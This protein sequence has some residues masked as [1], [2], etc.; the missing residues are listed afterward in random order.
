[1]KKYVIWDFNGTVLDDLKLSVDLLNVMLRRQNKKELSVDQYL[2]VFGFPI[3]AYYEKAGISFEDE[4]FDVMADFFIRQYQ[5]ESLKQALNKGVRE[6]LTV[7]KQSG[8]KNILLSASEQNNLEEQIKHFELDHLFEVVLG[9]DN[10]KA[11]GK[12]YKGIDYLKKHNINPND[13]LYIGDTTHD[14]EVAQALGVEVLL[15]TG[16]HQSERVLNQTGARLVS[17]I[18]DIIKYIE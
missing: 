2:E 15:Y 10:I 5:P 14:Y 9:T 8:V 6:T 1:M 12:V 16:G 3:K 7:L 17:S 11:H 18:S 4:S 13:C